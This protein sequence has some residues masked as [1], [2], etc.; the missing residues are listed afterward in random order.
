MVRAFVLIKL[1]PLMIG[2]AFYLHGSFLEA[3]Q[4]NVVLIVSDDQAWTDYGFMGHPHIR[5]PN[6]DKLAS[7]SLLF[8]RGYVPSSLCCP[9]L[10]TMMTGRYPHQHKITSN[11]P[12]NPNGLKGAAF[13]TSSA[14]LQGRERMNE[15]MRS[16][17]TIAKS[18]VEKGY[19][20][21]QTGKW[22]Q[23]DF[24]QGGFT[25]GMTRGGRHGDDGL[26]IGRKTMEPIT[27]FL[28]DCKREDKPFFVW[29]APM[30]PHD[31][32]TPPER[33]LE[34]YKPLTD[35]I[36]VA[37]YWAMVEWFDETIGQLTGALSDRGLSENTIIVYV[38]DNGWIQ[39]PNNPR[40]AARSK[41]SPYDG[42]LRTPIMIRWP[43]VVRP[44][45]SEALAQSIDIFPTIASALQIEVPR[46]LPGINLL[47]SKARNDRKAIYGACFTHNAVDLDQPSKNLRWRWMVTHDWKLIL[48]DPT[49]EPR[50][51]AELYRISEDPRE[52]SNV[53]SS[54]TALFQQL[55][56]QI[57]QWWKP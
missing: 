10:A 48:P 57:N 15:H 4:P 17:P 34:R 9:S 32:H 47:D 27:Q 25:H 49:N 43:G 14:F 23:G 19:L 2:A 33:I 42:G 41:Q 52:S 55:A 44:E 54:Q 28:D 35:S 37:R 3:R 26:A 39:D 56:G 1:F 53:A 45:R 13:N 8:T 22:W 50:E 12:P 38:T 16:V 46:D 51:T 21:L 31:P 7:E 36:H 40:Y 29:Y 5:T 30:M 11:D 24:K 18:L 6:L 20:A